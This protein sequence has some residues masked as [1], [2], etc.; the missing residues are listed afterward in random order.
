MGNTISKTVEVLA[1]HFKILATYFLCA[2]C[3]LYVNIFMTVDG[4]IKQKAHTQFYVREI[5]GT[6]ALNK[7]RYAEQTW[8]SSSIL[9]VFSGDSGFPRRRW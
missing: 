8:P 7:S 5:P 4:S 3:I 9:A 2:S 6:L 1:F